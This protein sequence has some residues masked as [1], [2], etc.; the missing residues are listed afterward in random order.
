MKSL[1]EVLTLAAS[2]SLGSGVPTVH[3]EN[4]SQVGPQVGPSNS[5]VILFPF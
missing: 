3:L 4:E 5:G 1:I 2:Q